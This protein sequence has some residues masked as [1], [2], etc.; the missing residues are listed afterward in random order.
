AGTVDVRVTTPSG[1]SSVVTADEYD[2]TSVSAPTLTDLSIDSG[3]TTGGDLLVITGTNLS[4]AYN[5]LF[6]DVFVSAFTINSA[7]QLTVTPPPHAAG[8]IDVVVQ[9]TAGATATSSASRFEFTLAST[10]TITGL[11]PSSG[12]TAGGTSVV[13]TGTGFTSAFT[14]SFGSVPAS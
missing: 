2:Y 4:G 6:G 14:V 8:T 10:P 7:E 9:T 13:I 1:T 12:S 11:S 5:I 3:S